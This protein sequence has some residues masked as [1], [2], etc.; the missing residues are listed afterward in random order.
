MESKIYAVEDKVSN[1]LTFFVA[2]VDDLDREITCSSIDNFL[3]KRN[4]DP[5]EGALSEEI[6]KFINGGFAGYC[7]SYTNS[8]TKL[9]ISVVLIDMRKV[10]QNARSKPLYFLSNV[11]SHEIRHLTDYVVLDRK[12][13]MIEIEEEPAV[14]TGCL[15]DES[16]QFYYEYLQEIPN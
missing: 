1:M 9:I 15:M 2:F 3:I 11:L 4:I 13:S 12:E 5:L 10:I 6:D 16:L 14:L 8:D 7:V